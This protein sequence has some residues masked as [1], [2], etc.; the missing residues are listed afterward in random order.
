MLQQG[1]ESVET[2]Q[3]HVYLTSYQLDHSNQL[4]SYQALHDRL[5]ERDCDFLCHYASKGRYAI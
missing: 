1:T 2:A 3:R 4:Q 5:R